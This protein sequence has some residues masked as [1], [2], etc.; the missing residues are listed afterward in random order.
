MEFSTADPFSASEISQSCWSMCHDGE[1][2]PP[3]LLPSSLPIYRDAATADEFQ[4]VVKF[5]GCM[6]ACDSFYWVRRVALVL[7]FSALGDLS[8]S[9]PLRLD[10]AESALTV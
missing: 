3:E 10:A 9:L 4:S 2:I 6:D 7:P 8:G 5:F 1:A